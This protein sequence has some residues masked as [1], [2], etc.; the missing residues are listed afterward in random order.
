MRTVADTAKQITGLIGKLSLKSPQPMSDKTPELLD[1]RTLVEEVVAPM[2]Q[3]GIVPIHVTGGPVGF[4]SGVR[5]QIHQVL[6]N[7]ILNAQQAIGQNG[8]ITITVEELGRS[9]CVT[10]D[11]TGAGIPARRLET[12]FR[13]LQSRRASGLGIGLYQSKQ[14]IEA[15]RGTVHV[16]SEEGKG[17][18]VHIEFP[19]HCAREAKTDKV[20]A[21]STIP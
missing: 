13:P 11:D 19:L 9:V 15:H 12:L 6:L 16:R 1:I 8:S 5:E 17:T 20:M 3:A 21:G 2:R 7:A 18:Q 4:M 10:I 14:I